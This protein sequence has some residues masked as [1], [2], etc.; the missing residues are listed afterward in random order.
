MR[1][2]SESPWSDT[3]NAQVKTF[4]TQLDERQIECANFTVT[5]SNVDNTVFFVG[6]MKLSG[7]YKNEFLEDYNKRNYQSWDKT[8]K[9]FTGGE[10]D[11]EIWRTKQE[12]GKKE[13]DS[14]AALR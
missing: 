12:T 4:V 2:Y 7:L 1:T 10:N 9:V 13:Y 14:A 6:H 5:I 3:P 8:A 11:Q